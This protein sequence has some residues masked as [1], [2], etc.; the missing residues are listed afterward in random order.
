MKKTNITKLVLSLFILL[1]IT[2]TNT[3]VSTLPQDNSNHVQLFVES[4]NYSEL[5]DE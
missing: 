4:S 3:S 5:T 2:F 1:T